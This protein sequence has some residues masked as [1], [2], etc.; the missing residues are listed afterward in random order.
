ML[1]KLDNTDTWPELAAQ[2]SAVLKVIGNERRLLI[3]CQLVKRGE[4]SVNALVDLLG[5]TQPALSQHLALMREEGIL[6]TRREGQTIF[7]RI[8][9]ARVKDVMATLFRLYGEEEG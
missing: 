7:Y 4:L 6:A 1:E 5:L 2:V 3:L 8:G 9:D